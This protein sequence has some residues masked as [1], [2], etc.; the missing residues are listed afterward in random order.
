[1]KEALQKGEINLMDY[2][3]EIARYYEFRKNLLI[4]EKDYLMALA[5][6]YAF[7]L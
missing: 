1:M 3:T 2:L 4:T 5:D 7:E 6:L